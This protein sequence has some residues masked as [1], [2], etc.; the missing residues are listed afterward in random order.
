MTRTRRCRCRRGS[1]TAN[2]AM[3]RD[4]MQCNAM[5]LNAMQCD[6]PHREDLGEER[7]VDL[8]AVIAL[9]EAEAK[10]GLKAGSGAESDGR[11]GGR[12]HLLPD[13]HASVNGILHATGGTHKRADSPSLHSRTHT[14]THTHQVGGRK[15]VP[16]GQ[17]G[18][19]E[20]LQHC[21]QLLRRHCW[22]RWRARGGVSGAA[23]QGF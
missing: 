20:P 2:P 17:A 13:V 18:H 6:A 3:Q 23:R 1:P 14:N 12:V 7:H 4:A 5:R 16:A 10:V 19:A 21:G 9:R 8:A 22:R 11:G 15:H